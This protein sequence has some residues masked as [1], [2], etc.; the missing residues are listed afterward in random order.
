MDPKNQTMVLY[1][2][3]KGISDIPEL[4]ALIFFFVL[5][6][7]LITFGG[8]LTILLLVFLDSVLHTP[9]YFFL[10]NL[11]VLDLSSI[12]VTLHKVL[13]MFVMNNN[14]VSFTE[15][16]AQV[17]I[18]SWLSGNELI[19]LTAM[20]YDRYVAICN[21]LHYTTVMNKRFCASLASF[22]WAISLLQILPP[23]VILA[24]FSCY[25]SHVINHFFCDIM[26]L[27]DLSCS[28]T[29]ILQFLIFTEGVLLSTFTPFLLTFIS[30]VFIIIAI[31]RIQ[32]RSGR[33]KAFYTCSSHL[34]VVGLHYSSLVFQYLTP[35]RTFKSNKILA[36]F[37]TAIVP[38]LNPVIYSLK[39]KDVKSA[40]QRKIHYFM[41]QTTYL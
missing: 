28:D 23:M 36:L 30:Y 3:L 6:I 7:Y 25:T 35:I 27:I 9:M 34:T 32:S 37:N 16:M 26:P 31:I 29:S 17:C 33:S 19:L 15:C 1:F 39:N 14:T 11:S 12:T 5:L 21:P 41:T 22:C 2:I 8:N 13:S 4:Q 24:R 10:C 38:M 40:I 18:F 20:S